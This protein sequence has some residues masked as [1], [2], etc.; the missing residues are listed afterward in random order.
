MKYL[1]EIQKQKQNADI[2]IKENDNDTNTL[3]LNIESNNNNNDTNNKCIDELPNDKETIYTTKSLFKEI[4]SNLGNQ[5]FSL[6]K[7]PKIQAA[8][9]LRE[10]NKKTKR[11]QIELP[12]EK[13]Y[14]SS[15]TKTN[16]NTNIQSKTD[17]TNINNT[18]INTTTINE[19]NNDI[20]APE[21]Q[22][23]I[24]SLKDS[25]KWKEISL[26]SSSSFSKYNIN[27][28]LDDE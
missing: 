15:L 4:A 21:T 6:D 8:T 25:S 26:I 28:S 3:Q 7:Y 27:N 22:I 24:F 17:I 12:D 14:L 20:Q 5:N 13:E 23:D 19:Y 1:Q 9:K 11:P 2:S 16:T 18:H 10:L